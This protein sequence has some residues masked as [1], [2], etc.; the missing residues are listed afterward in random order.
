MPTHKRKFDPVLIL[1]N[2]STIVEIN[3]CLSADL[4]CDYILFRQLILQ[5]NRPYIFKM[6]VSRNFSK[7]FHML[8]C[9]KQIGSKVY[10]V[11]KET[12]PYISRHNFATFFGVLLSKDL[13]IIIKYTTCFRHYQWYVSSCYIIKLA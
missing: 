6:I 8:Q 1:R 5:S 12:L 7:K 11:L 9:L 13:Q 4:L 2:T 3:K 10:V